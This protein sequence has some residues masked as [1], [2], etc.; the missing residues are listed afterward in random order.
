[1]AAADRPTIV[2]SAGERERLEQ[3]A[4]VE[5]GRERRHG[6]GTVVRMYRDGEAALLE[7]IAEAKRGR[8]GYRLQPADAGEARMLLELVEAAGIDGDPLE[9]LRGAQAGRR[10]GGS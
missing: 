6:D 4:R 7:R 5:L 1:M 2:L 10:R 8:R 9:R 3:V